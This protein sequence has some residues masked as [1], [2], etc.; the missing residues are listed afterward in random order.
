MGEIPD[1]DPAASTSSTPK[2]V[3][4]WNAAFVFLT[5]AV[6]KEAL[7][8]ARLVMDGNRARARPA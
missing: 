7:D 2:E 3:Y 4:N 5:M 1:W 6:C 8:R